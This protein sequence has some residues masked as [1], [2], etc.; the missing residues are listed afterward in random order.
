MKIKPLISIVNNNTVL[1]DATN[2]AGNTLQIQKYIWTLADKLKRNFEC[3]DLVPAMNTLT[4]YFDALIID[5]ECINA[6]SYI[7]NNTTAGNFTSRKHIIETHYNGEDIDTVAKYHNMSVETLIK[8]HSNAI[9]HV[10]FL[11]FQPGFAYLHGLCPSIH[12]PRRSE[13][14]L[15]VPKGAIAIGATQTGI[16]PA[17]SPGGW[18]IIAHT[19]S[20]LFDITNDARPCLFEP[21]DT[22]QFKPIGLNDKEQL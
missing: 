9:Y 12:T 14:R 21:G 4:L 16:Y 6:I 2:N 20:S 17:D 22:I 3:I 11:G 19:T 13:P 18:H 8:V 1:I 5:D 7:C 10:L 15:K